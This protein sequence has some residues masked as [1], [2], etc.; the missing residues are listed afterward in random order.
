MAEHLKPHGT[1]AKNKRSSPFPEAVRRGD[2]HRKIPGEDSERERR[3]EPPLL[4]LSVVRVGTVLAAGG[5]WR[6]VV[7]VMPAWSRR[8][9]SPTCSRKVRGCAFCVCC[10]SSALSFGACQAV[11]MAQ[12]LDNKKL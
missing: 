8:W 12:Q 3:R 5:L 9:K 2:P 7:G 4:Q 6:T 1:K 10:S 11:N